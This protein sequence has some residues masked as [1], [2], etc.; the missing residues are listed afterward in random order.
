MRGKNLVDERPM[1][2][3]VDEHFARVEDAWDPATNPDGYV[4]MCI[5]ENMLVWELVTAS[6]ES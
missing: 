4:A 6:I 2:A 5:A 1:P 3:Y